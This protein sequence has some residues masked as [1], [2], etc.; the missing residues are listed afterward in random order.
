ME[1]SFNPNK[2]LGRQHFVLA[3]PRRKTAGSCKHGQRFPPRGVAQLASAPGLGPGGPQ[4]E[5]GRPDQSKRVNRKVGSF[6]L[7][8]H[9]R[10]ELERG[11]ENCSFPV[12]E[13]SERSER[14]KPW[15]SRKRS[16]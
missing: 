11:R 15:V 3:D 5:S 14:W 1:E 10:L 16:A 13:G 8:K 12:E 9:F 7:S 6:T 4:F 2:G